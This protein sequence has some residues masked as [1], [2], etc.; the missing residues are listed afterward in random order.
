LVE[1]KSRTPGFNT[2]LGGTIKQLALKY[3]NDNSLSRAL[4]LKAASAASDLMGSTAPAGRLYPEELREQAV[5][6]ATAFRIASASGRNSTHSVE[7]GW[8][9]L[10]STGASRSP[11]TVATSA[12]RVR[13]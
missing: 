6:Y 4:G 11:R 13:I 10:P 1:G 12:P 7:L 3:M 9:R 2:L 8:V 5:P